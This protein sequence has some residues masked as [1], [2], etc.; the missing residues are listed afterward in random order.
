MTQSLGYGLIGTG[1]MGK[2]HALAYRS[3]TAVFGDVAAPRMEILCDTPE[4]KAGRFATQFG[5]QRATSDWRAVI[6]DPAVDIVSITTPNG[7]HKEMALAA[8]A[9]GKHVHLEKPMALTLQDAREM[10]EA[11]ARA[12]GRT[13]VGYNYLHN[14]AIAHARKLIEEGA[15][16]RPIHFRG[17]V[18]EDYQADPDLPWTWRARRADAGLGALGDLGCHLVSL[19]V[20]LLGPV[21]SVIAEMQTVHETRKLADSDERRPVENEDVASALLTFESGVNGLFSCSRSAWGRKSRIGLEIHGTKGMITYEQERMNELRLYRNDGTGATQGFTTILTGP[22]HPPYGEFVPA[23][24]H[25]L[26]FNDLKVIEVRSFLKAIADG[27]L[28]FPSFAD[29]FHYEAVIHAIAQAAES[30]A[31]VRPEAA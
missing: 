1:F 24:G 20:L 31:R 14:P 27:T 15:I 13:M 7:M 30:G 18:D 29:A 3:A 22:A 4:E 25:Q 11:A 10:A 17:L 19:A 6:D 28:T 16:G 23:P 5:F 2:C 9:A 21:A 26:G 12:P 8:L